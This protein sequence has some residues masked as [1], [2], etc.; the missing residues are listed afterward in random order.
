TLIDFM[1]TRAEHCEL[2]RIVV[3]RRGRVKMDLEFILRLDYG[4]S[5]PWVTQLPE[6]HGIRAIAG[7]DVVALRA[8]MALQ[9]KDLTHVAQFEVGEGERLAFTL[10]HG[11]SH[12]GVPGPFNAERALEAT[13]RGWRSW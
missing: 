9:A 2:A 8:P 12:L 3:G 11:A 13:E 1:P 6:S 5:V 10:V 7:P 4:T